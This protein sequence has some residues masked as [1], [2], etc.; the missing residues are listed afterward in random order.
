MAQYEDSNNMTT[1]V[2]P[3]KGNVSFSAGLHGW[4][5][6]LTTFANM[7]T[8]KFGVEPS[9]M[10]EKLWGDNFFDPKTKKW[11]RGESLSSLKYT[12]AFV[13]FVYE[14]IKT[15]IE[16]AIE[17]AKEKLFKFTDK[18][19]ITDK[20]SVEDKNLSGKPLM[21][22]VLQ[23]WIPAHTALLEMIIYHLPSPVMAQKYRCKILYK[24]PFDDKHEN[25]IN[26]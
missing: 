21:K 13:K 22:R 24:G 9:K 26:K 20:M 11:L 15:I 16:T 17:L 10:V 3:G 2:Y 14:P 1:Q 6:T 12:R 8:S 18:L 5:F 25:E 4:A 7:Y 19:E 23:S